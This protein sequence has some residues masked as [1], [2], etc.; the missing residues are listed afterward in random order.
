ML[1][2]LLLLLGLLVTALIPAAA[3]AQDAKPTSAPL[4]C[5]TLRSAQDGAV[6]AAPTLCDPTSLKIDP[7]PF[8]RYAADLAIEPYDDRYIGQLYRP[9]DSATFYF[10]VQNWGAGPAVHPIIAISLPAWAQYQSVWIDPAWSCTLLEANT[11]PSIA[12]R[13]RVLMPGPP[14]G[15]IVRM[16]VH[17]NMTPG[18][19]LRATASIHSMGEDA[20][21][22]NNYASIA[23]S[24]IPK[25]TYPTPTP[26]P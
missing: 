6:E 21:P 25:D 4:P 10:K 9:S 16:K 19:E 24:V 7:M 3:S 14:F 23:H 26:T 13:A 15:L 18:T 5:L 11:F 1:T 17:D 2:R 12:C 8:P 22:A 20:R